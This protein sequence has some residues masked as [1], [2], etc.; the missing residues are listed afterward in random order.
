MRLKWFNNSQKASVLFLFIV[1]KKR[2]ATSSTAGDAAVRGGGAFPVPSA[3][4]SRCLRAAPAAP[5]TAA[6]LH[7]K[8]QSHRDFGHRR[9]LP[10]S[11]LQPLPGR[12]S[13]GR[14][15]LLDQPPARHKAP[16]SEWKTRQTSS[17]HTLRC[18]LKV[19]LRSKDPRT[20]LRP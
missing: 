10:A 15:P 12:W 5:Q 1:S 11:R 16:G 7:N 3:N 17:I 4:P 13:S 2:C 19:E 6:T 20:W 18:T 8:P 9:R 14:W